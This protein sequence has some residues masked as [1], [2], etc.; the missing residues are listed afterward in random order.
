VNPLALNVAEL[1][2][3]RGLQ[4]GANQLDADDPIWD[5]LQDLR[6]VELRYVM[7]ASGGSLTR[8]PMLTP[9]GRSYPTA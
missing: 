1:E 3:I 2:A 8:M 6:L 9:Y 7:S 5:G 4:M